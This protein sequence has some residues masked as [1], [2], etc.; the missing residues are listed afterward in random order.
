MDVVQGIDWRDSVK[1]LIGF[2][3]GTFLSLG[4]VLSAAAAGTHVAAPVPLPPAGIEVIVVTAKRPAV[5]PVAT[6][7]AIEEFIVTAK[8]VVSTPARTP[9]AM[10]IEIPTFEFAVAEPLVIRL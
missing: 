10:A 8:R 7:E 6:A 5:Q 3:L 9:P 1:T 2:A 4:A